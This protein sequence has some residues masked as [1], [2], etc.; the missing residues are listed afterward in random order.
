MGQWTRVF[1]DDSLD[2]SQQEALDQL[3]PV[4]FAGFVRLSQTIERVPLTVG[5]SEELIKIKTPESE[6]EMKPLAGLDGRRMAIDGL[7]SNTFHD[8]VQYESVRHMHNGPD[9]PWSNSG[10]N[11]FT[12]RMIA[13]G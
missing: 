3:L 6:V 10:T 11:G 9:R 2:T 12:S 4:A 13:S 8:Y 1:I 5:R 7:P